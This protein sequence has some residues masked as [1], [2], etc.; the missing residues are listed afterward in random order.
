MS[1]YVIEIDDEVVK[2]KVSDILN[3]IFN[4]QIDDR[5]SCTGYE[6]SQAVRDLIYSRKDEIVEMV[7]ERAAKELV[8]KGLPKLIERFEQ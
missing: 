2:Q 5:S 1:R 4:R 7:V 8:R 6:I 3:D